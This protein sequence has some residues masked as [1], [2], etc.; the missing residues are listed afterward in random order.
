MFIQWNTI[1]KEN[2]QIMVMGDDRSDAIYESI[3]TAL[4]DKTMVMEKR[5]EIE[6]IYGWS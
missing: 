1:L 6:I 5:S 3:H 4:S 2:E